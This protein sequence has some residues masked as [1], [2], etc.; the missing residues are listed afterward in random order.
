MIVSVPTCSDEVVQC[1]VPE[2]TGVAA[3]PVLLLQLTVPDG[4]PAPGDTADTVAVNV[5]GCW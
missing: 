5:T 3:Q 2:E 4:A 1:A